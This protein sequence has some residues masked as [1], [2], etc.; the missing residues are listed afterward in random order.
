MQAGEESRERSLSQSHSHT[1]QSVT[2]PVLAAVMTD[3][4]NEAGCQTL[5]GPALNTCQTKSPAS[6]HHREKGSFTG[7]PRGEDGHQ[8]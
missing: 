6:A 4:E 8:P 3:R 7:H 1:T 5:H 2:L